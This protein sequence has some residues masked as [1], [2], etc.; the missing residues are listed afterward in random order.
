M[1]RKSIDHKISRK[2]SGAAVIRTDLTDA[3]FRALFEEWAQTGY[4]A[5]SL[6]RV[7]ARAGAGKAAIY[8]RWPSKREFA[9]AAIERSAP[10]LGGFGDHGSLEADILAYL[11]MTRRVLRHPLVRRILP[12]L[13]AERMRSGDLAP[14]LDHVATTRRTAG[15]AML[16]RAIARHELRP[17]IDREFA[18]D[19]IPSPLYWRM[20]VRCR[21]IGRAD[22]ERQAAVIANALRSC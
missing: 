10:G 13:H 2:P 9:S 12:D 22:L 14:L 21:P 3:L 20:I 18:F 8:R 4:A 17:D 19:L 7:A 15:Q 6:E 11:T 1:E 16:D 5:I